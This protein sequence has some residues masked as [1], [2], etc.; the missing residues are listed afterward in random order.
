MY[1]YV[2]RVLLESLPQQ[3]AD[4]GVQSIREGNE[5]LRSYWERLNR[6]V[7]IRPEQST[8]AFDPLLPGFEAEIAEILCLHKSREVGIDNG[9]GH[10]G[11]QKSDL[12]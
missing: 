1:K 8:S 6:F 4:A 9:A 7:A 12:E 10:R 11:T 2:F 3:L 5:F